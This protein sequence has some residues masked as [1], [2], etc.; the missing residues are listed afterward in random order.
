MA[1]ESRSPAVAVAMADGQAVR[2]VRVAVSPVLPVAMAKLPV[3]VAEH[4]PQA[5][6]AVLRSVLSQALQGHSSKVV[7]V[8][9]V[10]LLV[11]AA[12]A[13]ATSAVAVAVAITTVVAPTVAVA[14][15]GHPVLMQPICRR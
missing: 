14:V 9:M 7:P 4:S 6:V 11:A 1:R 15:A 3:A 5:V 10:K 12:V 13:A 8:E 2:E